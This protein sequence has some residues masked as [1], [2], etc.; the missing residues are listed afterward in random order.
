VHKL[1][2]AFFNLAPI[3][4][5][6]RLPELSPFCIRWPLFSS[7]PLTHCHIT[8]FAI[9]GDPILLTVHPFPCFIEFRF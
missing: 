5:G 8:M 4:I 6:Q 3:L 9:L 2:Y 7:G 1:L